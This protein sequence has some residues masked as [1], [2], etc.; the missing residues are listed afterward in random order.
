MFANLATKR[1]LEDATNPQ[2]DVTPGML[3]HA[4]LSHSH[5]IHM[6]LSPSALLLYDDRAAIES[7]TP[8]A[9]GVMK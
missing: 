4:E 2:D 8:Y 9:Q 1:K 5:K 7:G 6:L 3:A